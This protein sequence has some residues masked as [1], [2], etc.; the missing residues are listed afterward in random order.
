MTT[1]VVSLSSVI[2][3]PGTSTRYIKSRSKCFYVFT[4][5]VL[6]C[7]RNEPPNRSIHRWHR[8]LIYA[9]Y[10]TVHG[11]RLC[12]VCVQGCR[13]KLK[14]IFTK[15]YRW[16]VRYVI[17]TR[18]IQSTRSGRSSSPCRLP[19]SL[20]SFRFLG[21]LLSYPKSE[22]KTGFPFIVLKP[23]SSAVGSDGS[24]L[25]TAYTRKNVLCAHST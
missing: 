20:C 7:C 23:A 18:H 6:F 1:A 9:W 10:T 12:G 17:S 21:Q 4:A 8:D 5:L 25:F 15:Y 14:M 24:F 16:C 19:R 3:L 22:N 13:T 2:S 11:V